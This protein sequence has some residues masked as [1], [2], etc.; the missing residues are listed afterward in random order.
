MEQSENAQ[1]VDFQNNN[2]LHSTTIDTDQLNDAALNNAEIPAAIT[3]PRKVKYLDCTQPD[4]PKNDNLSTGPSPCN[5]NALPI[6]PVLDK[7]VEK[8]RKQ[9][10]FLGCPGPDQSTPLAEVF[11]Q[12]KVEPLVIQFDCDN[13]GVSTIIRDNL[14]FP[15]VAPTVPARIGRTSED[16][17]LIGPDLENFTGSVRNLWL[18]GKPFLPQDGRRWSEAIEIT[19]DT[20]LDITFEFLFGIFLM[21]VKR[22]IELKLPEKLKLSMVIIS[23]PMW[24]S[25][26]ERQK[27]ISSGKV[28]GFQNIEIVN[29]N[30]VIARIILSNYVSN[31][32]SNYDPVVVISENSG[33]VDVGIHLLNFAENRASSPLVYKADFVCRLNDPSRRSYKNGLP[34]WKEM[35]SRSLRR[36]RENGKEWQNFPDAS[37]MFYIS[38]RNEFFKDDLLSFVNEIAEHSSAHHFLMEDLQGLVTNEI[39]SLYNKNLL[40]KLQSEYSY[41]PIVFPGPDTEG[42]TFSHVQFLSVDETRGRQHV[43]YYTAQLPISPG[44]R[45]VYQLFQTA[46]T[47]LVLLGDLIVNTDTAGYQFLCPKFTR[48]NGLRT[49]VKVDLENRGG[50]LLGML[51][52]IGWKPTRTLA[53]DEYQWKSTDLSDETVARF[54]VV[55]QHL[56]SIV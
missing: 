6:L 34:G 2:V 36:L 25:H 9:L 26:T 21:L 28:A 53:S 33:V 47:S 15:Y 46:P 18:L 14:H 13:I 27:L 22:K 54:Q 38:W 11:P 45:H 52:R 23:V 39:I 44:K 17:W 16:R 48:H 30:N 12:S 41:S 29:E 51:R 49:L 43:A 4:P 5:N 35:W 55:I 37:T 31:R 50:K 8:E 19:G 56:L 1:A 42:V 7:P 32:V 24:H 3:S 40:E 20:Q 10:K